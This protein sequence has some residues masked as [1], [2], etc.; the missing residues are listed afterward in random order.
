[1]AIT[2]VQKVGSANTGTLKATPPAWSTTPTLGN[3]LLVCGTETLNSGST[4]TA[5]SGYTATASTPFLFWNAG[6][7][8]SSGLYWKIAGASEATPG[9]YGDTTSTQDYVTYIYE[10]AA[11][12]GWLVT[13]TDVEAH[14]AANATAVSTAASGSTAALAQADELAF[15][16][17]ALSAVVTALTFTNGYTVDRPTTANGK[18]WA[19]WKETAATT[20]ENTTASWTTAARANVKIVT[21]MTGIPAN[22]LPPTPR[23]W[24]RRYGTIFA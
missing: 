16:M 2:L 13:P 1:M 6:N 20:A 10:F 12:G 5:P 24:S 19:G 17:T 15:A 9:T 3:L 7:E 4:W 11:P 18:L 23:N 8:A 22:P 14:T 21:F